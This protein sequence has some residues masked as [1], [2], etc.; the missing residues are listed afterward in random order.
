M[1][2]RDFGDPLAAFS[3]Q[4]AARADQLVCNCKKEAIESLKISDHFQER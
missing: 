3:I 4:L 1:L 2:F